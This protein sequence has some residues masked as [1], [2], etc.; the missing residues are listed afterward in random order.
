MLTGDRTRTSVVFP[1]GGA[2]PAATRHGARAYVVFALPMMLAAVAAM[3]AH[4]Q[5]THQPGLDPRQAERK[6]EVPQSDHRA[7][8]LPLRAPQLNAGNPKAGARPLFV[9]RGVSVSGANAIAPDAVARTYHALLGKKVSQADLA[10]IAQA[11]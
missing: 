8:R 2:A 5:S 3:P 6:F 4:A 11:T 1:R 7:P 9:L 10:G